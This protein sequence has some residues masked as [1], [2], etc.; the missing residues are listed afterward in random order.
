MNGEYDP[1][2]PYAPPRRRGWASALLLPGVAFLLGLGVMGYVL[3]HWQAGARALG[4]VAEPAP[5][6]E[7]APEPA[8]PPVT[9]QTPAPAMPAPAPGAGQEP[10][11]IAIDPDL[12]RRVAELEQRIGS[13]D[14]Q[15]RAAVG[16]ADRAEGLLVAFAARRALDRGVSLGFLE[17]M[18]QQRFGQNQPN[19]VGRIIFASHNPV[20]LQD[21]QLGLQEAG[22]RLVGA[23]PDTGWW[24]SLKAELGSLI[25]VRREGTPST[26][27]SERLRR[28]QQRLDAGQVEVA[29]AE[30]LRIPARDNAAD[31]IRK[32]QIYVAA[33]AAL[34]AI[35]TAALVE[36]RPP[37]AAPPA[38][39]APPQQAPARPA[40]PR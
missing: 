37:A 13:V 27:P 28:A 19:A 29:L 9:V 20:T 11:R 2:D 38:P 18:L 35:E 14:T 31:W 21:L 33:R 17:S 32:A 40:R 36:Q 12:A 26:E 24:D 3:G 15:S 8:P 4:I 22:P 39:A 1:V 34:D 7:P 25:T 23:P 10:Q 5:A 16:N 30:V 6:V